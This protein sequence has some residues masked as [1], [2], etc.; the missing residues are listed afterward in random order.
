MNITA[1]D[2]STTQADDVL[3][4]LTKMERTCAFSKT[5]IYRMMNRGRAISQLRGVY[6]AMGD[7]IE[8]AAQRLRGGKAPEAS[9]RAN[10]CFKS[11]QEQL[12]QLERVVNKAGGPEKVYNAVMVGAGE[13]GT[14]LKRVM[15]APP[16]KVP[17]GRSAEPD[18]PSDAWPGRAAGQAVQP[19]HFHDQLEQVARRGEAGTVRPLRPGLRQGY[20]PNCP[21]GRQ[22]QE[23]VSGVCKSERNRQSSCG[24]HLWRRS[25]GIVDGRHRD[26]HRHSAVRRSGD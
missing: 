6:R 2:D 9:G 24:L 8:A 19:R 16:G 4:P 20:G 11:T 3:I 26:V 14:T 17:D 25:G 5:S 22:H 23:R 15:E 13:G 1:D 7:D 18:G 12:K 10:A 21:G